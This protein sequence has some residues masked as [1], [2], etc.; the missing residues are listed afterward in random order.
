MSMEVFELG[1]IC[2]VEEESRWRAGDG[3]EPASRAGDSVAE[4]LGDR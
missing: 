3:S 2:S 1:A 4:M